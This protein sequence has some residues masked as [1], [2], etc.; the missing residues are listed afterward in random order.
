LMPAAFTGHGTPMNA[1]E[2]NGYTDSWRTFARSLPRPRAILAVS[3]HWFI[4]ATAVTAMKAPKTIHDF[5]GFP[6]DL[7]AM[8]Y[9]AP[10]DPQFAEEIAEL[11]A[12][13][14]VGM[15]VD[16]W[17]I[18]HGTWSVL[19]HMF[20]DADI[21]VVQLSLNAELPLEYHF[22]L[23]AQLAPLRER[24]VLVVASGNVVHN[25]RQV[26]WQQPEHGFDWAHRFNDQARSLMTSAPHDIVAL[27][28]HRDFASAVPTTDHFLPLLY[29]AGL[30]AAAGT[31]AKVLVDGYAYGSLSMT[32]Y[33]VGA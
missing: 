31:N 18:D 21:P 7:F 22:E 8:Q 28:E 25:L 11:V 12:P 30:A 23:G 5:F 3:A 10:G 6:D 29:I 27:R 33:T 14:W 26:D 13:T 2:H 15:D 24:G 4:N 32:A 17:G 20:P 19:T 1:L 9:P 16:S